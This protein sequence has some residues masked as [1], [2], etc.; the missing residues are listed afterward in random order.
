MVTHTQLSVVFILLYSAAANAE[1]GKKNAGLNEWTENQSN[2]YNDLCMK[3]GSGM[4]IGSLFTEKI[5]KSDRKRK[6]DKFSEFNSDNGSDTDARNTMF[7]FSY[8]F[9][10]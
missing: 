2:C 9:D 3:L 8:T 6:T 7:G 4:E 5:D 10:E 1:L